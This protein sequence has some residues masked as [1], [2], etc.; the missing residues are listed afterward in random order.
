MEGFREEGRKCC[1]IHDYCRSSSGPVVK[2]HSIGINVHYSRIESNSAIE[3]EISTGA[4]QT[5]ST[6]KE[7][8]IVE[9]EITP[10][11]DGVVERPRPGNGVGTNWAATIENNVTI[12]ADEVA[13]ITSNA[14]GGGGRVGGA[15]QR[16]R[17][18]CKAKSDGTGP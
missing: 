18:N 9:S 7:G 8:K 5:K 1:G 15:I 16:H 13:T 17:V 6:G 3:I 10:V 2:F 14:K 4:I 12:H 11:L